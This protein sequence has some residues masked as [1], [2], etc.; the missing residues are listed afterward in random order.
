M[1]TQNKHRKTYTPTFKLQIVNDYLV[2]EKAVEMLSH[3]FDLNQCM[4]RRWISKYQEGGGKLALQDG[5]DRHG[6]HAGVRTATKWLSK[7]ERLRQEN[8]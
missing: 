4:I 7:I 3:E 8:L 1:Y 2:G 6:K 5:R